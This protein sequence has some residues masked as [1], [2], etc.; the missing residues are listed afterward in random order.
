MFILPVKVYLR[1]AVSGLHPLDE[2]S[3]N[4]SSNIAYELR[5]L[6]TDEH[7][8]PIWWWGTEIL[9]PNLVKSYSS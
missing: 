4:A 8:Q 2:I 7:L 5:M 1:A 6:F 3:P 9:N